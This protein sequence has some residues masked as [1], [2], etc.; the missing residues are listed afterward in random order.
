MNQFQVYLRAELGKLRQWG[1]A[2]DFLDHV[3]PA[4]LRTVGLPLH[5][6]DLTS[7]LESQDAVDQFVKSLSGESQK[8]LAETCSILW[9]DNDA[10]SKLTSS[11]KWS[12]NEV[13]IEAIRLQPAE[14][15]LHPVFLE[16]DFHLPRIATDPRILSH[17]A[18]A[19]HKP[20]HPVDFATCLAKRH[21]HTYRLFDGMHRAIQLVRNGKDRI[22]LCSSDSNEPHA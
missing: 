6:R 5:A 12:L 15:C 18:Y 11:T 9:R 17:Q 13:A 20:G 1:D 16:L 3:P 10:Y 8:K 2:C 19:S 22:P 4:T 14:P 7:R 21:Q